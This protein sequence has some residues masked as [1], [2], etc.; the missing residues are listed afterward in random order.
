M[1]L[2]LWS[3]IVYNGLLDTEYY[4]YYDILVLLFI[5]DRGSV[6]N[7]IVKL[8]KDKWHWLGLP[9]KWN[10]WNVIEIREIHW[11]K[12]ETHETT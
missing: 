2:C 9:K 4:V 6:Q 1:L 5:T 3:C 10:L 11:L 7:C 8:L 12:S